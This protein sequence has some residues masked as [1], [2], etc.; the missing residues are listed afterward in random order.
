M[1]IDEF[2]DTRDF[3]DICYM[4]DH[5]HEIPPRLD[6]LEKLGYK[7]G[8]MVVKDDTNFKKIVLSKNKKDF[9]IQVTPKFTSINCAK[10]VVI[11]PK[12]I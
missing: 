12:N 10:C 4:V 5:V 8:V 7:I 6:V 1:K 9:R 3:R 11:E 2:K